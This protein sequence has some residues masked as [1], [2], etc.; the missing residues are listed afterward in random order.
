MWCDVMWCDVM[1]LWAVAWLMFLLI[2]ELQITSPS[3][4]TCVQFAYQPAVTSYDDPT[5]TLALFNVVPP[6]TGGTPLTV[7]GTNFGPPS[8]PV[9]ILV[10]GQ[11]CAVATTRISNFTLV[12]SSVPAGAGV[13]RSPLLIIF[14]CPTHL[15]LVWYWT[16]RNLGIQVALYPADG[17]VESAKA[18]T[19][20]AYQPPVRLHYTDSLTGKKKRERHPR[21]LLMTKFLYV[22]GM[23]FCLNSRIW[24]VLL[25]SRTFQPM[26][27]RSWNVSHSIVL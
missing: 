1:W 21:N 16:G 4:Q 25:P 7:I 2:I 8:V 24:L 17:V 13:A 9:Q 27:E 12:C 23:V 3:P 11:P 26:E 22:N 18:S 6:T 19:L 14:E 20:F 10:G 5:I 15:V